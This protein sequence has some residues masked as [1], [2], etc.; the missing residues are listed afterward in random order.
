MAL[1]AKA[2]LDPIAVRNE[3]QL[4]ARLFA[5][6]SATPPTTGTRDRYTGIAKVCPSRVEERIAE[7]NGSRALTMCTK[8]T[9][10]APKAHTV[11]TCPTA[12]AKAIGPQA[13][14]VSSFM[15]GG[16]FRR[17]VVHRSIE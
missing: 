13:W 4:N 12:C 5:H 7:K 3:V 11:Q 8:L 2:A 1:R 14:I 10:D 17:P 9:V 6:A 16:L 15:F